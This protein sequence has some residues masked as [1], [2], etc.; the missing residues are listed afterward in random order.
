MFLFGNGNECEY[1]SRNIA[2]KL[3]HSL[4]GC[5]RC[6]MLRTPWRLADC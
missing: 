1:E 5:A 6:A 2:P 3:G 4:I